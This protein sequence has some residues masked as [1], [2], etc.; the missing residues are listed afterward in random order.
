MDI[1]MKESQLSEP[2]IKKI[3]AEIVSEANVKIK[4]TKDFIKHHDV[5]IKALTRAHT[6]KLK[7]KAE[8]RNKRSITSNEEK[9]A[10]KLE[11]ETYIVGLHCHR[12][13][14]EG[15]KF[16]NNLVIEQPQHGLMCTSMLMSEMINKRHDKDRILSKRV[17]LESLGYN[18]V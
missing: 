8:M 15:V 12:E 3:D 14:P 9:K 16:V 5:H 13:L 10:M 7:Q 2:V 6:E 17:K 11:P 18:D 4:G 1:A